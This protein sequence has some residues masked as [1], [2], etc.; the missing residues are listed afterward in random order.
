MVRPCGIQQVWSGEPRRVCRGQGPKAERWAVAV[1][2]VALS[3]QDSKFETMY[4][5]LRTRIFLL[6]Y[7]PGQRLS[8]ETLAEEFGV[9]RTPLRRVL[10][11]LESEGL[12]KS[13]RS[14]GTIVTDV[15]IEEL[16]HT[17]QLR[18]EL[19]ELLGRLSPAAVTPLMIERLRDVLRR[20]DALVHD[21]DP[22]RFARTNMDFMHVLLD[23]TENEPLREICERL[24]YKTARI[25]IEEIAD[26]DL[27]EE[28]EIFRREV[29]D[30]LAA[31]EI[32][33][34]EAVGHIRR[35]HISMSFTRLQKRKTRGS[36]SGTA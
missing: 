19:A 7:A 28:I 3:A 31:V 16:V 14:V 4:R 5:T 11:R 2:G 10:G 23:V 12:T 33:D 15:D 8:E 18:M 27:G 36:A 24:Y 22:R 29:A 25:W 30:I 17:Y 1:H 6:D 26:M 9:S 32:G 20:C 13:V 21:P 35:S 34:L